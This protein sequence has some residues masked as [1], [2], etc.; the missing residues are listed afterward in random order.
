MV[1]SVSLLLPHIKDFPY[2]TELCLCFCLCVC[3]F[4]KVT[5]LLTCWTD[6]SKIF[7]AHLTPRK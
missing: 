5:L 7:R 3:H 1:C 4:E 6:V 2:G